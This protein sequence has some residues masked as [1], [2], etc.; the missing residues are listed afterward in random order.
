MNRPRT[1][2][3]GPMFARMTNLSGWLFACA[4]R[5]GALF[6]AAYNGIGDHKLT[7]RELFQE[8]S[9]NE[10]LKANDAL[11]GANYDAIKLDNC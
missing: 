4:D 6:F 3:S 1:P 5:M 11:S 2:C 8:V 10:S 9:L 7:V